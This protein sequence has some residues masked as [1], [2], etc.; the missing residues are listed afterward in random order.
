MGQSTNLLAGAVL[1]ASKTTTEF[2]LQLSG[3]ATTADILNF[4][5]VDPT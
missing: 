5:V 4:F 1:T 3:P 2:V